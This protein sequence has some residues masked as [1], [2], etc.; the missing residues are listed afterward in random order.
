METTLNAE[1]GDDLFEQLLEE[2][3]KKYGIAKRRHAIKNIHVING[4]IESA[5]SRGHQSDTLLIIIRKILA[6]KPE[7]AREQS[8]LPE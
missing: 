7:P 2:E 6:L 4:I 8:L 3:K 1:I 5:H